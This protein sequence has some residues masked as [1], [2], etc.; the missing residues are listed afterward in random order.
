[1]SD[2]A[3][4]LGNTTNKVSTP[5]GW[6]SARRRR[7][8][9][10]RAAAQ[11]LEGWRVEWCLSRRAEGK[12]A[13][14][15]WTAEGKAYYRGLAVCGSVWTCPVCAAKITEKRRQDL[16]EAVSKKGF[17]KVLVTVTLQHDR[18]DKLA[19]LVEELSDALRRMK[20]GRW[21]GEFKE[22]YSLV[23]Y[24]S[25]LEVTYGQSGWHP[26]KHWLLFLDLPENEI[27]RD[28]LKADL[29][30]RYKAQLAKHGRY[31][32]DLYGIDVRIGD[33]GAAEY[34]GKWGLEAEVTKTTV[35]EGR[36][37]GL[38]PFQLLD[39]A[40][41]GDK[42]AGALFVEYA[43]AT[44]GRRQLVWSK[45]ARQILG[46]DEEELTDEDA[47][48]QPDEGEQEDAA[49]LVIS[50][51]PSQWA[52]I[53]RQNARVFVLEAAERGPAQLLEFLERIGALAPVEGGAH[54]TAF[55]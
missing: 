38:S 25:S 48:A 24:V 36:A 42:Q 32:S 3:Q 22:R 8:T 14:E 43:T 31:A 10:Q 12:S 35:K 2:R 55:A 50:F 6:K 53:L 16:T 7:Y 44:E 49:E 23:A 34:T 19:G 1:M 47:A 27:D 4:P 29:T 26:H 5:D 9:R 15:V 28:Q 37:G 45:G 18:T 46:L 33:Q 20:Q 13:V 54:E 51:E 40:A 11:L 30:A 17:S 52:Q 41:A 39:L 21:W